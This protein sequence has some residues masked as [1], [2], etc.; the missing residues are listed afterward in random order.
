[1]F[2][3]ELKSIQ[4]WNFIGAV[5]DENN[6]FVGFGSLEFCSE[7]SNFKEWY[8]LWLTVNIPRV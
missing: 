1:M 5:F 7:N 6:F 3:I 8:E 2:W 4:F